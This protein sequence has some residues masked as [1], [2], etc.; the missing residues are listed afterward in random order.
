LV[1][2]EMKAT[3]LAGE[4]KPPFSAGA[5]TLPLGRPPP[6]E[7][8]G[9]KTWPARQTEPLSPKCPARRTRKTSASLPP[10]PW[11][12]LVAVEEKAAKAA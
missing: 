9:A 3:Q 10:R 7:C 6:A 5:T 1:A 8:T 12:R 4:K 2:L 11:T